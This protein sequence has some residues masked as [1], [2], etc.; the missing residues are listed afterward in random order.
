MSRETVALAGLAEL[1][2]RLAELNGSSAALG[3]R[4]P[5]AGVILRVLEY[6]SPAGLRPWPQPGPRTTRAIDPETGQ[7]VVVSAQAPQGFVRV[8]AADFARLLIEQLGRPTDWLRPEA[9]QAHLD[10]A[11]STAAGQALERLAAHLPDATGR[12]QGSLAVLDE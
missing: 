11:I 5:E 6:G 2:A 8:Q 3:T 12:L 10:Q 7:E 4:D 1:F 9:V